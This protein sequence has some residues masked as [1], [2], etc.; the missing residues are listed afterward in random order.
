MVPQAPTAL[1]LHVNDHVTGRDWPPSVAEK[2]CWP[3]AATVACVGLT[4][5]EFAFVT[6]TVAEAVLEESAEEIAVTVNWKEPT[7]ANR[8]ITLNGIISPP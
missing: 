1:L 8:S 2:V 5:S 3:P 7:G 4:T 6:V